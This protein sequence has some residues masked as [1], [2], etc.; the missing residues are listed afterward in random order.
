MNR[1]KC[2]I[3]KNYTFRTFQQLQM[4]FERTKGRYTETSK[5]SFFEFIMR[6]SHIRSFIHPVLMQIYISGVFEH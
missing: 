3:T 4:I 5:I 6:N 2:N 1:F